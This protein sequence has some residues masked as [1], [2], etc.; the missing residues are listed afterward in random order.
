M[1][2]SSNAVKNSKATVSLLCIALISLSI[3]PSA[4]AA[5]DIGVTSVGSTNY[6]TS[7]FG[8]TSSG[9]SFAGGKDYLLATRYTL[10]AAGT[11]ISIGGYSG[12]A[13]HWKLGIYSDN[14]DAPGTL[15]AANNDNNAV[16]VGYN[17]FPIGPLFLQAGTYWIAI[18]SDV[19]ESRGM[20]EG[21]GLTRYFQNYGFSNSL[22]SSFGTGYLTKTNTYVAYCN[23]VQIEGYS[24]ATKI[25]VTD[26]NAIISTVNFY[27]HSTGNYRVAVYSDSSGPNT[28]LW[29]SSDTAATVGW[30]TITT[31]AGTPTSLTLNTGTYWLVYQWNSANSG[32][33]YTAGVNGDGKYVAMAYGSFPATWTS[34]TVTDQKWSIYLTT[35]GLIVTPENGFGAA[36]ALAACFGG[37]AAFVVYKKKA[38]N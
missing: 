26:S 1:Y 6:P 24:L 3:I 5:T 38:K 21:T 36:I 13:G 37:F 22:P 18:L 25:S 31:A 28:K 30:N 4:F 27:A 20:I 14:S 12:T 23:Y 11:V 29:E 32:P 19:A 7:T 15:L 17:S 2:K 33:S 35:G 34:G 16:S 9:T 10:S 8:T